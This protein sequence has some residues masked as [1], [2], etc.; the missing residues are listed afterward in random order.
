MNA[1]SD[2]RKVLC[3]QLE[4]WL[5]RLKATSAEEPVPD[6][7]AWQSLLRQFQQQ[8]P[9]AGDSSYLIFFEQAKT[10]QLL[11]DPHDGHIVQ[12]NTAAARFYGYSSE[13]LCA[14]RISQINC[15]TPA[16]I[17]SEMAKALAEQRS[18]FQFPHR[19]AN[20]D[21]RQ[22]EVYSG[23]VQ[24]DGQD[25]LY[26]II[27]DLTER[28]NAEA[29]LQIKRQRLQNI[30]RG[31]QAGT[32]EWN[33]PE[34]H[35]AI[36][37]QWAQ[38]LG[39][40]A[41]LLQPLT[42]ERWQA[43]VHPE[44]WPRINEVLSAH[45]A[46]QSSH[47]ECELRMR[48]R[49]GNWVWV[50]CR[51]QV[52]R[53]DSDGKPLLIAGIHLDITARKQ[54]ELALRDSEERYRALHDSLPLGCVLLDTQ[55]S[56]LAV[57]QE[58]CRIFTLTTDELIGQDLLHAGWQRLRADGQPLLMSDHP[59]RRCIDSG[60][61]VRDAIMGVRQ[62]ATAVVWLRVNCQPLLHPGA[63]RPHA[64][65]ATLQDI[66]A[67]RQQQQALQLAA[68]VF[69]AAREAILITD[70]QGQI[71]QVNQAFSEM[72]GY[73]SAEVVG[74][75]PRLL[76]SG[77]QDSAFYQVFWQALLTVGH[78]SGELWN[79]RKNGDIFAE[80][81]TISAVYGEG[82]DICHFVCL[83][84]DISERKQYQRQLEQQAHYDLLTGLPNRMLLTDR[85]PEMM[86]RSATGNDTPLVVAYIDLDGFKQVNDLHGHAV[87]DLLLM[88]LARRMRMTLREQDLI[89]RLGGDEF[90]ALIQG[91]GNQAEL[92]LLVKRLLRV[93][94]KPVQIRELR[95]QVSASIGMAL[96][97]PQQD[98]DAATLLARADEAMYRV[99]QQ[100][101]NG[102]L[103]LE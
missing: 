11:I 98:R 99:K 8:L 43:L 1:R 70:V 13:Q 25:L 53:Q 16:Q 50:L 15:L 91:P 72:T 19:L 30:L 79:R 75:N 64:V 2:H 36:N 88:A 55:L 42:P 41:A 89:A 57:N 90:V 96:Y 24:L 63:E 59:V 39:Y 20:G 40:D 92:L 27:Y 71:V 74:A 86:S 22:V 87:G 23:P 5:R 44:D 31:T 38:M 34:R 102:Y 68:S 3:Q 14:M 10:P 9:F 28:L 47:I 62:P 4:S 66:T 46:A 76:K 51:G 84:T 26:S 93:I 32:W 103:L 6:A 29:R 78:W 81:V 67:E 82:G 18:F 65:I 21:I 101:K 7:E 33:L 17:Q 73:S 48:H 58:A 37:Q 69:T 52:M 35:I 61:P 97:S 95:L 77:H 56:I 54:V 85:L 49:H 80:Q 45:L 100:G 12:A 94:A 60:Q 83:G